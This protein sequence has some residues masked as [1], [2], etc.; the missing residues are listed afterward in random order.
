MSSFQYSIFFSININGTF[1]SKA[2]YN[3]FYLDGELF[4]IHHNGTEKELKVKVVRGAAE[5]DNIFKEFHASEPSGHSGK[6]KT[7]HDISNINYWPGMTS[8]I[9]KLVDII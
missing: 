5:A 2:I 8:E 6:E 7:K 9:Q 3:H 1:Q 4:Y